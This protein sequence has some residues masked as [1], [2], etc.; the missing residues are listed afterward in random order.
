MRT[1][2]ILT[3]V[4]ALAACSNDKRDADKAADKLAKHAGE[5]AKSKTDFEAKKTV[6]IDGLRAAQS[7][8]AAQPGMITTFAEAFP[9]ADRSEVDAK[10]NTLKMR[11]DEA[12]LLIQGLPTV[13]PADFKDRDDAAS[14]AMDRL[15][16]AS[17]DAWKAVKD[18]KYIERSS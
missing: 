17:K 12:G 3:A 4:F 6:R 15:E 18:A 13:Q 2:T 9:L 16:D 14:K 1:L 11:L 5:H 10:L 8:Y 7:V